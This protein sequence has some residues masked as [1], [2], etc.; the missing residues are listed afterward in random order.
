VLFFYLNSTHKARLNRRRN[1]RENRENMKMTLMFII[2]SF[3][4]IL[5]N[6][7]FSVSYLIRLIRNER[8]KWLSR[9]S[10]CSFHLLI[11]L[12]TFVYYGFNKKFCSIL[13]IWI[14]IVLNVLKITQNQERAID[15]APEVVL[16][17]TTAF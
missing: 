10:L 1:T 12:K 6:V 5:G 13:N 2:I 17:Q 15:R 11:I 14:G 9:V 16:N 7:P 3:I 4:Y 8:V